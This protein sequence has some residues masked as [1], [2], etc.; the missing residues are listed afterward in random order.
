MIVALSTLIKC[1]SCQGEKKIIALGG[2]PELCKTCHG[3][4]WIDK[5][6]YTPID[7][8]PVFGSHGQSVKIKTRRG[9]PKKILLESI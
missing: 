3:K 7:E 8:I 9:R 5:K 6:D 2:M 4:G 1:E